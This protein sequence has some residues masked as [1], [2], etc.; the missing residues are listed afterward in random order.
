MSATPE[1]IAAIK[2]SLLTEP[3]EGVAYK[4]IFIDGII[5]YLPLTEDELLQRQTDEQK[6]QQRKLAGATERDR[7]NTFSESLDFIDLQNRL[8]T[9]TASQV[10]TWVDNNV[11]SLAEART[12]LKAIIKLLIKLYR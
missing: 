10:N 12:V 11:T 6:H 9:A 1:Q 2:A 3:P 8:K 4:Q 7:L 5:G